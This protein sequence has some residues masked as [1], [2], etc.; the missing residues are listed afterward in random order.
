MGS[1]HEHIHTIMHTKTLISNTENPIFMLLIL[2]NETYALIL[3]VG[4]F[5]QFLRRVFKHARFTNIL[6]ELKRT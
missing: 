4:S 6:A 1:I 5:L 2:I 3:I